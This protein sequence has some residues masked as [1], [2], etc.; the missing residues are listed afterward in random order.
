MADKMMRIAGRDTKGVAKPIKISEDGNVSVEKPWKILMDEKSSG[1][2]TLNSGEEWESPMFTSIGLS[3]LTFLTSVNRGANY[4]LEVVQGIAEGEFLHARERENVIPA[5]G[6][7]G[8][9]SGQ[10]NIIAPFFKV[11]IK[12][13]D[14]EPIN[15]GLFLYLT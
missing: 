5:T 1:A 11:F 9:T 4:T 6:S 2:R 12:N 7:K 13:Q 8:N 14:D 3:K 15:I 10:T